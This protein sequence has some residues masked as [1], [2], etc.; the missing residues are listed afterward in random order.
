MSKKNGR[1]ISFLAIIA[2]F[3]GLIVARY[4]QLALAHDD[5]NFAQQDLSGERGQIVDRNGHV[6]AM[7][8]PKYNVS[9]WRPNTKPE[10]FV[11]EIPELAKMLGISPQEIE[12][13]YHDGSQNYFYIAKRCTAEQVQPVLDAQTQGK[14]K[15]VQVDEI[16]GRLTQRESW[17][18]ILSASQGKAIRDWMV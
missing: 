7:D 3:A 13:K 12:A 5:K 18:R 14:F 11:G 17:H 1:L 9:I 2:I 6:L 4:F 8:V 10:T 16:S 15:G